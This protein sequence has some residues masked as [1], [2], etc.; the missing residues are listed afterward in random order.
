MLDPTACPRKAWTTCGRWE[1]L[2]F[3]D[4]SIVSSGPDAAMRGSA[5]GET[6]K[7]LRGSC[8]VGILKPTRTLPCSVCVLVCCVLT[9]H[10]QKQFT[11]LTS[12]PFFSLSA[13]S[14]QIWPVYFAAC[15]VVKP[16]TCKA[17]NF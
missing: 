3:N 8:L 10:S 13:T 9:A 17:E 11:G 1:G 12:S 15:A 16:C 14:L 6:Y 5:N 7:A 4:V 2:F